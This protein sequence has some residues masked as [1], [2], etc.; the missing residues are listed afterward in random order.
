MSSGPPV[1]VWG[2]GAVGCLFAG[3][4]HRAGVPVTL[5]GRPNTVAAVRRDG[6]RVEG[7]TE[8]IFRLPAETVLP[9]G[10]VARAVFLTVKAFDVAPAAQQLAFSCPAPTPLLLPQ[11]GLGIEKSTIPALI[12][13]GWARDSLPL[14]RGLNSIPSTLLGPG[15][16]R[17]AGSGE[18]I[19]GPAAAASGG[20]AV[21]VFLDLCRA[22]GLPA[23]ATDDIEREVWRK[24]LVNAAI[25][26]VTADHHVL[27]GRLAEDPWRGQ[28]LALLH[29]ALEVARAEGFAFSVEEAEGE[30]FRVVR[31]TSSNRSSMLQDVDR[32]RPTEVEAIC[33][34]ISLRAHQHGIP[35]PQTDRI[36]LR[37]RRR[38]SGDTPQP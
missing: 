24:L 36:L 1:V 22:A 6:I 10:T 23:R 5:V 31:A 26:P 8:G 35:V 32:G 19:L 18:L 34:E 17:H 27:N 21:A 7:A 2:G 14:V 3:L 20:A 12:S 29:E 28:A 30:L 16:V 37:L 4:L 11:N 15:H 13:S 33:G 25:N 38:S 9:S